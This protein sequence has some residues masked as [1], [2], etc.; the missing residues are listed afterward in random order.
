MQFHLVQRIVSNENI[1]IWV[2]TQVRIIIM[3]EA[4]PDMLAHN[5]NKLQ[6]RTDRNMNDKPTQADNG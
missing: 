1:E 3:I 5:A 2:G 6:D 4:N